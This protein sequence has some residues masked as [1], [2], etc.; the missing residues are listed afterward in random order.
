MAS[1]SLSKYVYPNRKKAAAKQ[2]RAWRL[3]LKAGKQHTKPLPLPDIRG[4]CV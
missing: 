2:R 3:I 1:S 4:L